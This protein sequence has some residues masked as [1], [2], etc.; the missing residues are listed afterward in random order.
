MPA[1]RP[2]RPLLIVRYWPVSTQTDPPS[3]G[4]LQL[5]PAA[6]QI[7]VQ[8]GCLWLP[9]DWLA[10]AA[11]AWSAVTMA[12][13][14]SVMLAVMELSTCS[15]D[16]F[17]CSMRCALALLHV[18]LALIRCSAALRRWPGYQPESAQPSVSVWH[19]WHP[20]PAKL[21]SQCSL[22]R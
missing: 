9:P 12:C 10:D 6:A 15:R 11:M 21:A 18:V 4:R 16:A 22:L 13:C 1:H 14:S 8:I 7:S 3:S 17:T 5:R 20:A 2:L 19:S